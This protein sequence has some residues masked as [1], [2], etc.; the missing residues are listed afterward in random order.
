MIYSTLCQ[1]IYLSHTITQIQISEYLSFVVTLFS[2]EW[3]SPSVHM[4]VNPFLPIADTNLLYNLLISPSFFPSFSCGAPEECHPHQPVPAQVLRALRG[5]LRELLDGRRRGVH[6]A[7]TPVPGTTKEVWAGSKRCSELGER[8]ESRE[9]QWT[10]K[11]QRVRF[12]NLVKD[13]EFRACLQIFPAT[14]QPSIAISIMFPNLNNYFGKWK[15]IF[16]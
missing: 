8:V 10:R 4:S 7:T 16:H 14:L 9:W 6:K 11:T 15:V 13:C 5:W 1:S 2:F 12:D 3:W